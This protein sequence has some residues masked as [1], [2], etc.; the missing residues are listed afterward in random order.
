MDFAGGLAGR[1]DDVFVFAAVD[2]DGL[3]AA[4]AFDAGIGV[5]LVAVGAINNIADS[6]GDEVSIRR[7]NFGAERC[8]SLSTVS[9]VGI[10]VA[11]NLRCPGNVAAFRRNA[12]AARNR[13]CI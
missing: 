3:R 2:A 6:T 7:E 1:D 10:R 4:L 11:V 12:L 9:L 8:D 5:D 13:R